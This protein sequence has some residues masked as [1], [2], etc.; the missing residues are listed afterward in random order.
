VRGRK[1][2]CF[3]R[4]LAYIALA[5]DFRQAL[6]CSEQGGWLIAAGFTADY[7]PEITAAF[8]QE[9]FAVVACEQLNEWIAIVFRRTAL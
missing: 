1:P 2:P 9:G 3:S 6:R 4:G 5:T 7:E 8:A